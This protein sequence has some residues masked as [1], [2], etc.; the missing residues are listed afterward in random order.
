MQS[1]E[2]SGNRSD[3]SSKKK[4]SS[5]KNTTNTASSTSKANSDGCDFTTPNKSIETTARE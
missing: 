4:S 2:H 3:G 5:S 1:V